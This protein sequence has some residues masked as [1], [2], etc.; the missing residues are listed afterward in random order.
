M[1][2]DDLALL[3]GVRCLCTARIAKGA[4]IVAEG[5]AGPA[6]YN[7][8][9]VDVNTRIRHHY[10]RLCDLGGHRIGIAATVQLGRSAQ[11]ARLFLLV[12][13]LVE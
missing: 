10:H 8:V 2:V 11:D 3:G 9:L 5:F 6:Q 12:G 1:P 7:R 13:D 4:A